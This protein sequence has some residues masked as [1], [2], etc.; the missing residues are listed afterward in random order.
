MTAVP[1]II[2]QTNRP[3]PGARYSSQDLFLSCPYPEALLEGGRGG[4][5]T[6]ALLMDFAQDCGVGLGAE[7][8]GALFRRS[9]QD[10]ADVL[11]KSYKIFPRMFPGIRFYESHGDYFWEWPTGERL[12]FRHMKK[13]EEYWGKFHGHEIP[14]QGWE[15]LSAWPNLDCYRIMIGCLRS[16]NPAVAKLVRRRATTNPWGPGHSAVKSYFVD[17]A[18]TGHPITDEEGN[19]R[20]RYYAPLAENTPLLS[21]DPKYLKRTLGGVEDESLKKAWAGGAD[22]WEIAAGAFFADVWRKAVHVLPAWKPPVHWKV[23]RS[24]D[25]GSSAPFAAQW[26]AESPGETVVVRGRSI[27][28]PRGTLVLFAQWYGASAPSVGLKMGAVEVAKEIAKRE[29][30]MGVAVVGGVA[31]SAMWNDQNPSHPSAGKDFAANGVKMDPCVKGPGSRVHGW[32]ECRKRLVASLPRTDEKG[33]PIPPEAPGFYVT[34]NCVDFIRTIPILE[35][36]PKDPDEINSETEDHDADAWRY[37]LSWKPAGTR[38]SRP[39]DNL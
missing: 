3:M 8:R 19:K 2:W 18:P 4:G 29:K 6:S 26:Y 27:H 28:M 7:W 9:F 25:W 32:A 34:D 1:P 31:D 5:K 35:R 37:R 38:T 17:P 39:M 15:E 24:L 10:L 14:W 16:S 30:A 23:T 12:M 21:A 11:A 36:D 22:R 20:V 33:T 13:P